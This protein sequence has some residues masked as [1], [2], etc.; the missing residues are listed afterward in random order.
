[1]VPYRAHARCKVEYMM[2][3]Y[4][5]TRRR[6]SV[7]DHSS[8]NLFFSCHFTFF[9]RKYLGLMPPF[10]AACTDTVLLT[11]P[12]LAGASLCISVAFTHQLIVSHCLFCT[13]TRFCFLHVSLQLEYT[14]APDR[15]SVFC[16][17]WSMTYGALAG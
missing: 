6:S 4:R 8:H 10:C 11:V 15:Y 7:S 17:G 1:M 5:V 13:L 2:R 12:E 3:C 9:C 14:I 16:S